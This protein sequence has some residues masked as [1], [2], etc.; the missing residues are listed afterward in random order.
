LVGGEIR[1]RESGE[2]RGRGVRE[3]EE[4]ERERGVR[5]REER[6]RGEIKRKRRKRERERGKI[7]NNFIIIKHRTIMTWWKNCTNLQKSQRVYGN[8]STLHLGGALIHGC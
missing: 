2:K 7:G 5:E 1:G 4:W 8:K 3:R 6:E